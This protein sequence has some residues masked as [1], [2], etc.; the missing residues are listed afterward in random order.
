M[1]QEGGATAAARGRA[2]RGGG[3][4][5]CPLYTSDV[6]AAPTRFGHG[7][8]LRI[9]EKEDM[10]IKHILK[11]FGDPQ[12]KYTPT[13]APPEPNKGFAAVFYT[14]LKPPT[15]LRVEPSVA[16]CYLIKKNIHKNG[17]II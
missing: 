13:A 2:A 9:E 3:C 11:V 4:E 8:W 15:Y 7:A 17:F 1:V 14:H 5:R 6:C 12:G 10:K 16:P